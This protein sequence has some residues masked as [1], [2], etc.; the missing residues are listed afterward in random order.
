MHRCLTLAARGAGH[1]SPNPM[2][3]AVLVGPDG[4]KLGEG[5]HARYGEAHAER[6]AIDAVRTSH[7]PEALREATLYV[8]LEPCSHHGK[9]PPCSDL[10]V[11][12]GIPRVVVGMVDPYP[13]VA[14]RG[15]RRLKRHGVDVT[16][17][18]MESACRRLNEAFV[19]HVETGQPLVTL[20]TAQTLDGR[21]AT[22]T[23]DSRWVT[24]T[25]ARTLVHQWRAT[26][27]GVLVG[28]GTA[29]ADDPR[30]TVRHVEGRQPQRFVLD[31]TGTLPPSLN[32][33]SDDHAAHTT[34]FVAED[35]TPAY[36]PAL[37]DAGGA[38][39]PVPTLNGHLHLPAL[40]GYLGASGGG[41]GRALQ[42]LLVEAGPGLASALLQQ[43]LVDRFFVFVAPKVLGE[44][45]PAVGD[46]GI[47]QMAD[48]LTFAE[49]NWETV[50]ADLLFRGYRRAV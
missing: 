22:R 47:R 7:G 29:R 44:G 32:L 5:Y 13:V 31:R 34:V 46:L 9:Q 19:H 28:S 40:L 15:I 1:V 49:T 48:A 37:V 25:E 41:N 2:V 27:D 26:L 50:G 20:K 3:G 45:L 33:F 35:V 12:T 16:V 8:S 14:G 38:V 4:A 36:R 43:E 11:E 42:S 30:L 18:V 6:V 10:I 39:V 17:G 21:V 23:G 24:G